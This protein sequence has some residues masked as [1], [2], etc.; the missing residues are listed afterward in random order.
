MNANDLGVRITFRNRDLK[1]THTRTYS[2]REYTELLRNDLMNLVSVVE[3]LC[4]AANGYKDK[5]EWSDETFSSFNL[6]KHKLLDKA[7]DIGRLPDNLVE[8]RTESLTDF[9]ARILNEEGMSDGE[10]CMGQDG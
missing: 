10:D 2:L 6:I 7:G 9:V 3:N 4:Y 1:P 8:R 5:D